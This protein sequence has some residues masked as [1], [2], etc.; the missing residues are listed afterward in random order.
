M[1]PPMAARAAST[2]RGGVC[3]SSPVRDA[4]GCPRAPG[5]PRPAFRHRCNRFFASAGARQPMATPGE[6]PG[7]PGG[8]AAPRKR[9]GSC[10]L[11][12]AHS[13]P[14][15]PTASRNSRSASFTAAAMAAR[16][17]GSA[18]ARRTALR[19]AP[20]RT[21]GP[22]PPS[23]PLVRHS[24][25]RSWDIRI[26]NGSLSQERRSTNGARPRRKNGRCHAR[27]ADGIPASGRGPKPQR[28]GVTLQAKGSGFGDRRGTPSPAPVVPTPGRLALPCPPLLRRFSAQGGVGDP[29][30]KLVIGIRVLRLKR[31]N[32]EY[33][34][35][36]HAHGVRH[37]DGGR[38][39]SL[40][41]GRN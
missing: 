26:P 41:I 3:Q 32:R 36:G 33:R 21:P 13:A 24:C 2:S 19:A 8:R 1:L 16:F 15:S 7:A 6:N 40:A 12:A 17:A 28:S 30:E 4:P 9:D 5:S 25:V 18:M 39:E 37:R 35:H 14:C 23:A 27:G 29:H 20:P 31:L 34:L 38:R 22:P 11:S 10:P